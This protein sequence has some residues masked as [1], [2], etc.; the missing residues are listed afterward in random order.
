MISS[1]PG[2]TIIEVLVVTLISALLAGVLFSSFW[3]TQ[4]LEQVIDDLV[5]DDQTITR[6]YNQFEKDVNGLFIPAVNLPQTMPPPPPP[7]ATT[8]GQ[9]P[10]TSATS[11]QARAESEQQKI[12]K[13]FVGTSKNQMLD[14]FTFPTNNVLAVYNKQ[15]PLV[16]RV[17]YRIE[18]SKK[19]EGSLMLTRQELNVLDAKAME[20]KNKQTQAYII[21]DSISLLVL[22]YVYEEIQGPPSSNAP[23]SSSS[24]QKPETKRVTTWDSDAITSNKESK[25]PPIP[26]RIEM[27]LTLRNATD[28]TTN[29]FNFVF[30]ILVIQGIQEQM[31]PKPPPMPPAP[32]PGEALAKTGPTGAKAGKPAKPGQPAAQSPLTTGRTTTVIFAPGG[33]P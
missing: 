5:T 28:G 13:I 22:T 16:A 4:R 23:S 19:Y 14:M 25:Q 21:A 2:F 3:Q 32:M 9:K 10:P 7:P 27:Q 17:I 26:D 20:E 8:P 18:P 1:R 33:K 11:P 29:Q 31:R 15:K 30:P 6:L 24:G 12:T